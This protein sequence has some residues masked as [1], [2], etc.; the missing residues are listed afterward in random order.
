M[1]MRCIWNGMGIL[2]ILWLFHN[3]EYTHECVYTHMTIAL[4]LHA[5]M[6]GGM[7]VMCVQLARIGVPIG[8]NNKVYCILD[9][10][11]I[12]N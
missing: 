2:W 1:Q 5:D 12:A 8:F 7:S 6:H 11:R 4:Q 9:L 3:H 10:N